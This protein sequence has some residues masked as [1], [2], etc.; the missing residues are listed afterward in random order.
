MPSNSDSRT[1]TDT[2][3]APSNT[4]QHNRPWITGLQA[5]LTGL[6][7]LLAL[8]PLTIGGY[9]AY[10]NSKA[11][12]ESS[13]GIRLEVQAGRLHD[14]LDNLVTD[15]QASLR[16]WSKL[17][18][19][20]DLLGDDPD[21]QVTGMLRTLSQDVP[22]FAPLLALS[23]EGKVLASSVPIRIGS[24]VTKEA[25]FQ[26]LPKN[27]LHDTA[28]P[29]QWIP[30]T[31]E[32]LLAVPVTL[33]KKQQSLALGWLVMFLPQNQLKTYIA[34]FA[35]S[36]K[37]QGLESI[38]FA[39]ASSD[40]T[41]LVSPGQL[42]TEDAPE[43]G[44]APPILQWIEAHRAEQPKQDTGWTI[45][46]VEH[47]ESYL[48]GIME[49]AQSAQ[50]AQSLAKIVVVI[51][52]VHEAFAPIY[53]LRNQLIGTGL[54]VLCLVIPL[55]AFIAS[56]WT[57]PIKAL[58]KSAEALASGQFDLSTLPVRRT[59]EIGILAQTFARMT[60]ELAAFTQELE[61]RVSS[62]TAE[63][64]QS[65]RLLQENE[66]R[67]AFMANAAPV[68]IAHLDRDRRYKFVNRGYA[69]LFGRLPETLIGQRAEDVVGKE[70][71]AHAAPYMEKALAGET[72]EYDL[73][74]QA[75]SGDLRSILVRY[76][77]ER[78][79]T[80]HVVGFIAAILDVTERRKIEAALKDSEER[81][82]LFIQH[83]PAALAMFDRDMRYLAVS[84]RWIS[85]YGLGETSLIGRSHYDVFPDIPERWKAIH[86][87]ALAGEIV[88]SSED[89]F[90]RANGQVLWTQW[91][92]RPWRK[93]SGDVAGI[94]I[95]TV[96]ITER[97]R[98]EA[99]IHASEQR[100]HEMVRRVKDYAIVMLDTNGS[101][102]HWN[103][104]AERIIGYSSDEILGNPH[105]HFYTEDDLAAGKPRQLLQAALT[106]DSVTDEGWRARKDGSRFW[107]HVTVTAVRD[108]KGHMLGYSK[109]IRDLTAQ[110]LAEEEKAALESKLLQAQKME[111]I[112]SLAGGIAHDFNNILTVIIGYAHMG[113]LTTQPE[114]ATY[115]QFDEIA[116]SSE[117]AS[118]LTKSLLAFS[119]KQILQPTTLSV[120]EI[121]TG[122][123]QMLRRLIGEHIA[124]E[125]TSTKDAIFIQADRSQL[126]QVIM[127]LVVNARDAMPQGG[128]MTVRNGQALFT[129][130]RPEPTGLVPPGRYATIEVRDTGIGMD[131][132]TKARMFE[133]FF[134]TKEQGKGTG[135]GLATV[136]GV[137][138]QSDGYILIESE[139]GQGARFT[140]YFPEVAR[141]SGSADP[142]MEVAAQ[143]EPTF[144]PDEITVLL[145]EDEIRIRRLLHGLLVSSGYQV[146]TAQDGE[147][148]LEAAAAHSGPIHLLVTDVVMPKLSGAD[149]AKLLVAKHPD[150][151]VLFM[152]G[153]TDDAIIH[154]GVQAS[155]IT[156]I[157]KP[158]KP[159]ILLERLKDL[160]NGR[161]EVR[162]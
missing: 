125:I 23:S 162:T 106:R 20:Y 84:R 93:P 101:V 161:P 160:L 41:L 67:I 150:L 149:M 138:K 113:M 129:A 51:Q 47:G 111:A 48:V 104:G 2:P 65:N 69:D 46:S 25:W 134:T 95:F 31:H 124:L 143:N 45:R 157:A 122:M 117:R 130:N 15:A 76:A 38:R 146:L 151:K 158:F 133:P 66:R 127:N 73:S 59:D 145:V 14:A 64:N 114:E 148:G 87:R 36:H 147:E 61:A 81:L 50:S 52:P 24:S 88:Q 96:D 100:F 115:I 1:A 98:A 12:L 137:V 9:L 154:H 142:A 75:A 156:F 4:T 68:F 40:G 83:A 54:V 152:S 44:N 91:E 56:R 11:A 58:T 105:T 39:V 139:P 131:A 126:E 8:T 159:H 49:T 22:R 140:V 92:V 128:R 116:K 19:M 10:Y 107:S 135:L 78:N 16:N 60:K 72:V 30:E 99:A 155:E 62:R 35:A 13:S 18:V 5:Q 132:V 141:P 85:D 109:L 28:P 144:R 108:D 63:L 55:A 90:D 102:V 74:L 21:G 53:H 17:S 71:F 37:E 153:Y 80:G 33:E 136:Y 86:R 32:F 6:L 3:G 121:I 7:L 119:R 77:P 118:D 103:E 123:D 112:G 70:A 89:R 43:E 29:P 110:K 120:N 42:N 79:E 34:S 57:R 82:Q 26:R 97:K 27:I 94:V